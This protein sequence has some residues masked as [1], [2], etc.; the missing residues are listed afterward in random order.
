[1]TLQMA[2][3]ICGPR[4]AARL[5]SLLQILLLAFPG[6]GFMNWCYTGLDFFRQIVLKLQTRIFSMVL[7]SSVYFLIPLI[8]AQYN[9]TNTF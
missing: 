6:V 4:S 3:Q 7:S 9:Y 2:P 5:T 1:M 8:H